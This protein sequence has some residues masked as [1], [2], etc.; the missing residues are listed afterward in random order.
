MITGSGNITHSQREYIEGVV[1]TLYQAEADFVSRLERKSDKNPTNFRGRR[2]SLETVANGSLSFG[3]PSG[4]DLAT[5]GSPANDKYLVPYVWMNVG[6]D[7][8]YESLLN[9]SAGMVTD[10]VRRAVEATAK[11]MVKWLNIYASN[12]DGTTKLAVASAAY[13]AGSATAFVA[14]GSTDT[15]G[16]SQIVKGMKL[17]VYDPTGTTQRVGTVGAGAL[18]VSSTTGTQVTFSTNLPSDYI[19]GDILVPEGATPSNGFFGVPG[20]VAN[21]GTIYGVSRTGVPST[22]STIVNAGGGLSAALLF[23]TYSQI[24]QRVGKSAVKGEGA[25]EMFTNITQYAA[26]YGLTTA[27]AQLLFPRDGM[28]RPGIDIGGANPDEFTWFGVKINCMLDW[29]GSRIDF[30]NVAS[31][32]IAALKE[33]GEML[34]P[35]DKPLPGINGSTNTYTAK[36]VQWWDVARQYYTAAAH[37]H[38]ALTGLTVTGYPMQKS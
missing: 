6:L 21:S 32:K 24:R 1:E 30:L 15:I 23:Q 11:Q 7:I 8:D 33:G 5:P 35:F 28:Q 29:V 18:T 36:Q 9:K 4:G 17:R 10:P 26:Y 34:P 31:L 37:K 27:T 38:G 3:N 13:N 22:A 20:L 16:A 19:V 2:V 25:V 14:N 12:G